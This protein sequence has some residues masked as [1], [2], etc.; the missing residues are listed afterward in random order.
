MLDPFGTG[1]HTAHRRAVL[2]MEAE[3]ERLLAAARLAQ[4]SQRG[5]DPALAGRWAWRPAL[6]RVGAWLVESGLRLQAAAQP[7]V[8]L[9]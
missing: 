6:Y 4:R 9:A 1:V 3:R 5:D 8:G 7:R 2:L